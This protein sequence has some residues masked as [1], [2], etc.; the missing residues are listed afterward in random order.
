MND[1]LSDLKFSF[2]RG[3]LLVKLIYINAFAF[4][5]IRL[6]DILTWTGSIPHAWILSYVAMP[7]NGDIIYRPWTPL[8]NIFAHYDLIHFLCNIL[9]L[10]WIGRL[11]L[12]IFNSNVR[13]FYAYFLGGLGG[14]LVA[15]LFC[16]GANGVLLGA[17]G[18]I[19]CML[20]AAAITAPRQ[21]V[22]LTFFGYVQLRYVAI[23]TLALFFILIAGMQN[24]GGNLAHLG[25]ALTGWLLALYWQKHPQAHTTV[26]SFA[27]KSIRRKSHMSVSFNPDWQYNGSRADHNREVD[28]ILEKIHAKGY[29][30]L[31]D[32]EKKTLFDA[33]NK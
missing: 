31:T 22:W 4:L 33:T 32:K 10:Y 27:R 1:I 30:S 11:F 15:L 9:S 24:V 7:L 29:D 13:L 21:S 17:S 3:G 20:V 18:A 5:L 8:T 14:S 25:G 12:S 26:P 6:S 23:A 2:Q 28:R 19:V 16:F